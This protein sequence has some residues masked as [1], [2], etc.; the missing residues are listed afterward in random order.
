MPNEQL[1]GELTDVFRFETDEYPLL[2]WLHI[3]LYRGT[4]DDLVGNVILENNGSVMIPLGA[5]YSMSRLVHLYV[6]RGVA[7]INKFAKY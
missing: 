5:G 1:F 4:G 6:D 7:K 2:T 3:T